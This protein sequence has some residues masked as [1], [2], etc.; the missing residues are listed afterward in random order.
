M[1]RDIRNV[2]RSAS[3]AAAAS[4]LAWGCSSPHAPSTRPTP[5]DAGVLLD[6]SVP[7]DA[8]TDASV[9]DADATALEAGPEPSGALDPTFGDGGVARLPLYAG[10]HSAK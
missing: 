2:L 1:N 9:V 3:A 5:A 10:S 8:P 7:F 6:S 4:T